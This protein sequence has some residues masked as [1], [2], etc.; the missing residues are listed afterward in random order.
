MEALRLEDKLFDFFDFTEGLRAL[1]F[2][3]AGLAAV[4]LATLAFLAAG[5]LP[6]VLRAVTLPPFLAAGFLAT[7]LR[8]VTLPAFLAAGFLAT[9]LRAVTLPA[10]L[11]AG[12]LATDLRAV[13]LPAFLAAGFLATDLRAVTL[14]AFL[15]AG[16]LATDLRAVTLPVVFLTAFFTA[17]LAAVDLAA[18]RFVARAFTPVL[19]LA[20][21]VRFLAGA[22]LTPTLLGDFVE[23]T[24][25]LMTI[26]FLSWAANKINGQ[27]NK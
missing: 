1:N 8:A 23:R 10:F 2:L 24:V 3:T 17:G 20:D 5:F 13:T 7:D 12:F 27:F 21:K 16:F 11:A 4:F 25:F 15:A 26:S 9:D 22:R 6:A 19:F 18:V 14:P